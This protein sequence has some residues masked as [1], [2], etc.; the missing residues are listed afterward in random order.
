M[1]PTTSGAPVATA[2]ACTALQKWDLHENTNSQGSILFRRF[3][4]HL[5]GGTQA[6][7]EG[8][9][10]AAPFWQTPFEASNAVHT[11]SGL[12]TADPEVGVALGDAI[13]DLQDANLPLNVVQSKVQFIEKNGVKYPIPGGT[14]DPNG[15]FN[16]IWTS[17]V[18]GKGL[19]QPDG[20]SSF[21]QVVTWGDGPCPNAR[22]ILTYSESTDPTN[23]HY[24]DQTALFSKKKWVRDRFC[25]GAIKKAPVHQV[26]HLVG[27]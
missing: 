21:V 1:A 23:P 16:A 22:T 19:T 10:G 9:L 26:T 13:K 17:W 3:F 4:D 8:V 18:D 2:D 5:A 15:D 6:T 7:A 11:P 20:G 24:A 25:A 14:G 27:S 12:N